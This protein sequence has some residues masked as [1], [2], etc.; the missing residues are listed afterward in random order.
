MEGFDLGV[1]GLEFLHVGTEEV[2]VFFRQSWSTLLR[3]NR[4]RWLVRRLLRWGLLREER[5]A[6]TR[7]LLLLLSR[8]YRL[9]RRHRSPIPQVLRQTPSP[10]LLLRH[11]P[12]LLLS[13]LLRRRPS[14]PNWRG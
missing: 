8:R 2:D 10:L 14:P 3:R 9:L 7:Y 12:L 6:L 11:P 13:L 1:E 5:C 4:E